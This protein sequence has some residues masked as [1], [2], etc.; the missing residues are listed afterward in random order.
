MHVCLCVTLFL[1]TLSSV[2]LHTY[3]FTIPLMQI[4]V[5]KNKQC[6]VLQSVCTC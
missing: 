5:Q 1:L 2:D 3:I 6:I 4:H